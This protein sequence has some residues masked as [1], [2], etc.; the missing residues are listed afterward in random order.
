MDYFHILDIGFIQD[1]D[2]TYLC[3]KGDL[4]P[5]IYADVSTYLDLTYL[6]TLNHELQ[7]KTTD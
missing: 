2:D 4:I 5:I 7:T 3:K 6:F 1:D